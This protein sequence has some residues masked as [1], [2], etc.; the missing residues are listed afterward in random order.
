M[1]KTTPKPTNAKPAKS[2]AKPVAPSVVDFA[3]IRRRREALTLTLDE[4]GQAAGQPASNAPQWWYTL[5]SGRYP[6]PQI[7]KLAA[8]ARA[9]RCKVQ[10]L[11]TDAADGRR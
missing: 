8:A 4:A 2:P 1:A 3:E 10:D 11:L 6:D 5:E 9:L 7:S